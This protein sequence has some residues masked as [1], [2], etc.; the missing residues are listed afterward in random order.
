[1]SVTI[2]GLVVRRSDG[3]VSVLRPGATED[4]KTLGW[5]DAAQAFVWTTGAGGPPTGAAGGDLAGTYPNP[6]IG[7]DKVTDTKLRNSAAVSVIGRSA[8]S[9]GDPADI[10]AAVDD[11]VLARSSSSVAFQQ[12]SGAM[13]ADNVVADT[14]LRQGGAASV[15]GRSAASLGNVAD[16]SAGADGNV[17]R[18]AAGVVGFGSIPST[19]V[20]GLGSAAAAATTDF[21]A[22]GAAATAQTAAQSYAD[23]LVAIAPAANITIAAGFCRVVADEYE[24]V[25]TFTTEIVNGAILEIT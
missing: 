9:V 3:K 18:R 17:L 5:D 20:T 4:G 10:A 15:I 6:T 25:D 13:I 12:V 11:R 16:I 23:N 14:K 22:T 19:S 2:V 8:N 24:V 7:T 1:M 21:D